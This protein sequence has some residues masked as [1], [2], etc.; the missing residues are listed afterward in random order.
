MMA[1]VLDISTLLIVGM[2][3]SGAAG[4]AL[5]SVWLADRREKSLGVF[6]LALLTG[7]LAAAFFAAEPFF[8]DWSLAVIGK[9]LLALAYGFA[10]LGFQFFDGRRRSTL[11]VV[12][13]AVAWMPIL[14]VPLLRDLPWLHSALTSLVISLYS[15]AI[16]WRLY[17]GNRVEPLPARMPAAFLFAV[18]GFVHAVRVPLLT[19]M[20]PPAT[21]DGYSWLFLAATLEGLILAML[22]VVAVMAMLAQRAARRIRKNADRDPLT[23]LPNRRAFYTAIGPLIEQS[24]GQ[25]VLLLFDLDHF[26]GIN[27]RFGQENGDHALRAFAEAIHSEVTP[28]D[29]FAR[30]GDE[31]F[32]LFM[33]DVGIES[34]IGVA[35]YL[36]RK[37][38]ELK[39]M[40][41]DERMPLTTSIGVAAVSDVGHDIEALQ[42]AADEALSECKKFGRNRIHAY[43]N[44]PHLHEVLRD[45]WM[46]AS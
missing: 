30:I 2:F 26:R 9:A 21:E 33:A 35:E 12:I 28:P 41:G 6:A 20:P 43:H 13:G 4:I 45:T 34:G 19:V 44:A 24:G 11:K 29:V 27:D 36:C 39:L 38:E 46:K 17:S 31:E 10:W 7:A 15:F 32:A 22:M 5:I 37:T 1:N 8:G 23:G 40:V 3:G 42:A 14:A 25:G 16:V 18:H